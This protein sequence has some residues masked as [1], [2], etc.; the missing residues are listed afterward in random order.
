M[1]SCSIADK[2]LV[3]IKKA[4]GFILQNPS[5]KMSVIIY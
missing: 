1:G 4:K 3:Q 5:Y 2:G